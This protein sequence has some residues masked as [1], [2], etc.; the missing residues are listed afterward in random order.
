V[1]WLR[2][3]LCSIEV[4]E[5]NGFDVRLGIEPMQE[6][7]RNSEDPNTTVIRKSVYDQ[8]NPG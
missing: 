1:I 2:F 8:P 7:A 3:A 4:V 5:T 6:D